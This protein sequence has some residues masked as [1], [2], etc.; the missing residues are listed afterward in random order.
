MII[1]VFALLGGAYYYYNR[2]LVTEINNDPIIINEMPFQSAMFRPQAFERN[3]NNLSL[4]ITPMARYKI[5]ARILAKKRYVRGWESEISYWDMV[6][7][8][9]K[10][11]DPEVST[12]LKVRQSVRWYS[13]RIFADFPLSAYYV[14]THS[15]NTHIIAAN[16]NIRKA[17]LFIRKNDIVQMEGYLVNISGTRGNRNVHWRT[18]LSR[19]DSGNGACEIFWVESLKVGDR[20]YK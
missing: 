13:F 8:W 17:L 15:A 3:L 16:E 5:S 12:I 1:F 20:V 2:P 6:L 9:G 4:T 7:G 10:V 11:A 18:S 14:S 19:E